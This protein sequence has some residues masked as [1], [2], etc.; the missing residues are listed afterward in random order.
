MYRVREKVKRAE[1]W[2]GQITKCR[3]SAG[4]KIEM[5]ETRVRI[6]K[7]EEKSSARLL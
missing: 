2:L 3:W 7:K 6:V 5:A 1:A 4:C